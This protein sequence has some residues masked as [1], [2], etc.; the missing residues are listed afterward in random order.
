M[1]ISIPPVTALTASP[2]GKGKGQL[3][4]LATLT[5]QMRVI[6]RD[7]NM[8]EEVK[9]KQ[10]ALLREQTQAIQ[11]A[12]TDKME[13]KKKAS[14]VES[15]SETADAAANSSKTVQE[16]GVVEAVGEV[17]DPG[18]SQSVNSAAQTSVDSG[19][20]NGGG[21]TLGTIV[22]TYA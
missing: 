1:K 14:L 13:S 11:Q 5:T 3:A 19:S 10:I 20:G 8:P 17:A 6:Q 9:K 22:D 7:L 2:V 21:G 18:P 4:A 12:A 15:S 16:A